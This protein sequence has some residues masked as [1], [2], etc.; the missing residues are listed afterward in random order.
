VKNS[1]IDISLYYSTGHHLKEIK[2]HR[3]FTIITTI[4]CAML[5]AVPASAAPNAGRDTE[6]EAAIVA[7]LEAMAPEAVN[8][9][10]AATKALDSRDWGKASELFARVLDAAPEFDHALRRSG[11][12]LVQLGQHEEGLK[13]HERSLAVRR[14]PENLIS[15]AYSLAYPADKNKA[16]VEALIRALELAD[17]AAQLDPTDPD[18]ISL[19]AHIALKLDNAK[20]FR[21]TVGVLLRNHPVH[22]PTHYLA[23]IRAAMDEEWSTAEREILEAG[24]LGLPQ[25]VVDNFLAS[26][27]GMRARVWRWARYAAV[28]FSIW[29]AGILLLFLVGKLLSVLTLSSV[30]RDDPNRQISGATKVLRNFYRRVITFAG[31]YYYLSLPFVAAI[32][33]FVTG[34]ILYAFYAAGH[35]PIKLAAVIGIGALVTVWAILRSLFVRVRDD[36][37][38]GL[39]ISEDDAPGL[40][41]MVRE[42]AEEVNTRPVDEIWLTPGTD[43]AVYERG[44]LRQRMADRAR[45]ALIIGAGVLDGFRQDWMRAVLAHEYGHFSHRDTAGGDVALRVESGMYR[46][47]VALA[48]AGYAVWWNLGFQFL[49]L[50]DK[51]FRRITHGATRMQEVLA[52]RL[53]VQKYGLNAFRDGLTHV[54]RRSIIFDHAANAEITDAVNNK[55]AIANLYKLPA[56]SNE[57]TGAELEKVICQSLERRTSEDDTHPSP[58]DRFRLASRVNTTPK[59]SHDGPVWE[60]FQNPKVLMDEM[61]AVVARRISHEAG[62]E[63][64]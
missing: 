41:T 62:V 52:D 60:L 13:H 56:P 63:S 5:L 18:P 43:L 19:K 51:L 24:R 2:M 40:W 25:S 12:A 17:E 53:A 44:S 34:S 10:V 59:A 38:P 22:M 57:Q 36:G 58:A 9:F 7:E 16:S 15:F 3:M 42:V 31:M 46:F 14:S 11:A 27:I 64:E 37:D 4:L 26:G 48:E 45:R 21:E 8:D 35:I 20:L 6:K 1:N 30:E 33:L 28:A 29:G 47:A 50:Y 32:V 61:T 49:R 55:R 39:A 23:A 54:V